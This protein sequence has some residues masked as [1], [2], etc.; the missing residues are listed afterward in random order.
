MRIKLILNDIVQPGEDFNFYFSG[1]KTSY[2]NWRNL[3][4][5]YKEVFKLLRTYG[6]LLFWDSGENNKVRPELLK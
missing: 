4:I 5:L 2:T 6:F 1:I 3:K